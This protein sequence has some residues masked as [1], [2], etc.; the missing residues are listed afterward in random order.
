MKKQN[1]KEETDLVSDD[2]KEIDP[3]AEIPAE[4]DEDKKEDDWDADY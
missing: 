4:E 3:E 2:L 1:K